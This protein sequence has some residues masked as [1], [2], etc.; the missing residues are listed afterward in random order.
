MLF[1]PSISNCSSAETKDI[2]IKGKWSS[3]TSAVAKTHC[4]SERHKW[5][6]YILT[7][8]SQAMCTKQNFAVFQRPR[9][10]TWEKKRR[11]LETASIPN[12]TPRPLK[13]SIPMASPKS[14]STRRPCY[15]LGVHLCS[16][17]GGWAFLDPPTARVQVLLPPSTRPGGYK[18]DC[19]AL[20]PSPVCASRVICEVTLSLVP[21]LTLYSLFNRHL[22]SALL[23]NQIH[24]VGNWNQFLFFFFFFN[25]VV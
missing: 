24:K 21:S 11:T 9:R 13:K 7:L 16:S 4:S 19:S 5:M 8:I 1:P 23:H 15:I 18:K 20:E 22:G 14:S 25:F 2:I 17:C 6:T 10:R 3:I 12:P